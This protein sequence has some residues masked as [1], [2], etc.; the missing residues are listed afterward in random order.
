MND[1]PN[2]FGAL[3]KWLQMRIAP[4]VHERWHVLAGLFAATALHVI[5]DSTPQR[6]L[7]RLRHTPEGMALRFYAA[8]PLPL[9]KAAAL[10]RLARRVSGLANAQP[11]QKQEGRGRAVIE[12][13]G[14]AQHRGQA[15]ADADP[16]DARHA[17]AI[18]E[19]AHVQVFR[20][21]ESVVAAGGAER[22]RDGDGAARI[23]K[24]LRRLRGTGPLR[25]LR[26]PTATWSKMADELAAAFPNFEAVVTRI[27]RPHLA[28]QA[29]G[30]R[31]RL[32]PTLLVG[33]PGI[34]KTLFSHRLAELLNVPPP[35]LISMASETNGSSIAGSSTFWSNASP[36]RLFESLAWGEHGAPAV[37][38][39][40]IL[41]DEIDKVASDGRYDPLGALYTLLEADTA[42]TFQDQ[43]LPDVVID[44]SHLR[45]LCTANELHAIPPA[46]RSRMALFEIDSPSPAQGREIVLAIFRSLVTQLGV[47]LDLQLPAEVIDDAVRLEP[48]RARML[49]ETA[50][51]NAVIA[52]RDRL[53]SSDWQAVQHAAASGRSKAIGFISR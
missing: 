1:S 4:D 46:L 20:W 28:L 25:P 41:L 48:R 40:L 43:S 24:T 11:I 19:A 33:P 15:A 16:D 3:P 35:V 44:A 14:D 51:A 36:G 18:D 29:R 52:D 6:A 8:P 10:E 49:L 47:S 50:I 17:G 38:N 37:A 42:R 13:L 31:H 21:D 5:G 23:A 53:V 45:V 9:E 39:G 2:D 30:I 32:P 22:G 27:I 26:A 34:G 12:V 7:L